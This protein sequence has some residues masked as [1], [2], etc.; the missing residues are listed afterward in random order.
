MCDGGESRITVL[1]ERGVCEGGESRISMLDQ[2]RFV[3]EKNRECLCA[4]REGGRV[5]EIEKV[6]NGLEMGV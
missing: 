4:M 1:D 3:M 5:R 2:R 6:Y